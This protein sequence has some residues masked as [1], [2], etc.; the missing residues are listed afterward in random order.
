MYIK[1]D[2]FNFSAFDLKLK[3]IK[4]LEYILDFSWE[5]RSLWVAGCV[6]LVIETPDLKNDQ[7]LTVQRKVPRLMPNVGNLTLNG[8]QFFYGKDG[9]FSK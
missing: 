4:I 9:Y 6:P 1:L 5:K 3:V 2:C 7:N 8:F